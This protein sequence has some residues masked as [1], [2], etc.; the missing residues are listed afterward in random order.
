MILMAE[1]VIKILLLAVILTGGFLMFRGKLSIRK[2]AVLGAL[3]IIFA[4]AANT[5]SGFL[6][7]LTDQVTLTAL[8]KNREESKGQEVYLAGF[9]IDGEEFNSLDYLQIEE[10]HWFW[11]GERYC[12]RPETDR[13]QPEGLTRT[14]VLNIPVGWSRTLDFSVNESRGIVQ[15]QAGGSAWDLDTYSKD[16]SIKS[17][18][19]GRSVTSALVLNSV[20]RLVLYAAI[21]I[22]L[23]AAVCYIV[24]TTIRDPKKCGVWLK[25]KN[26]RLICGGIAFITFLVMFHYA[27]RHA[28]WGDE[29]HNIGFSNGTL[30]EALQYNL[31]MMEASPPLPLFIQT[32]W[33]HIALYG[34]RWLMLVSIIPVVLSIYVIGI[35]GERAYG[36]HCGVLASLFMACSLTVW[37][38]AALTH[39]AYAFLTMFSTLTL[40]SYVLRNQHKD[41]YKY[42]ILF[43]IIMTGMAMSHYFGMIGCACFF[44][45]DVYLLYR[46]QISPR[47][48]AAY[49]IPGIT[50]A[51]WLIMV[52]LTVSKNGGTAASVSWM[53]IPAVANIKAV[54]WFLAGKT[55]IGYYILLIGIA[56]S[57]IKF[58]QRKLT[59]FSWEVFYC[60]FCGGMI[61]FSIAAV[62]V[63]GRWINTDKTMW[64]ERYFIFLVPE[65]CFLSA[66]AVNW[67]ACHIGKPGVWQNGAIIVLSFILGLNIIEAMHNWQNGDHLL[68]ESA[69]WLYAQSSF[70]FNSDTAIFLPTRPAT[71]V[72]GWID[73]YISRGGRRDIVNVI[74]GGY[75][76]PLREREEITPEVILKYNRIYVLETGVL[77]NLRDVFDNNFTLEQNN[78]DLKIQ[79]YTRK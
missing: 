18:N 35:T 79:V 25:E 10:G 34:E 19:I 48:I 6:P 63:Y 23:S 9:T 16:N 62:F 21:L 14:V 15:I 71:M 36:K 61:L 57:V 22:V 51:V 78:T 50:S 5:I 1:R 46:K 42:I 45:G 69:D 52:W 33:H 77:S 75:K 17:E 60:I 43:G 40:Y 29:L 70:I 39:K 30:K 32:I 11:S 44:F 12:W 2:L 55:E 3:P 20:R 67:I 53:T 58:M 27:G 26:G 76:D 31:V 47:N 41:R 56:I 59:G 49:F 74:Y 73:Y 7:S 64:T 66:V 4:F 68:K 54:L 72:E 65:A 8:G 28:F 37:Q 38:N 13:R 24:Q